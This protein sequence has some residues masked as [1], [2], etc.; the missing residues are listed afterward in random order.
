MARL[1][2]AG[3]AL[4]AAQRGFELS[5]EHA[6][7]RKQFGQLI[8]Q[9]QAVQHKLADNLINLDGARL[10][11]DAAA[12]ARDRGNPDW[13]VFAAAALAFAGPAL[14]EVTIQTHRALGA[15][16]YAEEHEAPRHF[17]RVHA[18]LA[19]FGGVSRARAELADH[20]LGPG[21]SGMA[22]LP[23][24]DMGQAADAFRKEVRDWLAKNWTP[25]RRNAH[26]SKP[27]KE[28]GWDVEFSKLMGRDGLIGAGWPKEF[29]GQGRSA[30]EQI[31][32]I[33]EM[34]HADAPTHAHSTPRPSSRMRCSCTAPRRSRTNGCRRS[35]AASE[36]SASATASR[37]P[38]LTWPRFAPAPCAT[39][40][41]G[42]STARSSGPPAATRPTT[43][44][45]RCGPIRRRR[46]TPASAC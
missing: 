37:R 11:L 6:K 3:R 14:R 21:L 40:T 16:G 20:L 39:A 15:I 42:S 19:R 24:H 7:V 30:T 4:G 33:T 45:S 27:F 29:G 35:G 25:E 41:T 9:F 46:S 38:A 8:G 18:D 5:V 34:A 17:R 23:A 2:C 36:A 32:L 22:T 44:G 12:E 1:A 31:A 43:C 28:R 13:R 26:R 10:A